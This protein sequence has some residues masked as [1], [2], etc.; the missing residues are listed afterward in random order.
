MWNIGDKVCNP[1]NGYV[2]SITVIQNGWA[3][4][5]G[6]DGVGHIRP[7]TDLSKFFEKL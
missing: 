2:W 4:L 6:P 7:I 3:R 1:H 5:V